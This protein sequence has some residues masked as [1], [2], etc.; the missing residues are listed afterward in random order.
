MQTLKTCNT[1]CIF[2]VWIQVKLGF[3]LRN[4]FK[5]VWKTYEGYQTSILSLNFLSWM[6]LFNYQIRKKIKISWCKKQGCEE[7]QGSFIIWEWKSPVI[8]LESLECVKL[9]TKKLSIVFY[10]PSRK[11]FNQADRNNIFFQHSTLFSC[12]LVITHKLHRK[13]LVNSLRFLSF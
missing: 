10:Q 8:I 1:Y 2:F 6:R 3:L 4:I 13:K 5:F 7:Y 12:A 9:L 11:L